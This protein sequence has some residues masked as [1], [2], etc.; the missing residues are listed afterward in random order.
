MPQE[1]PIILKG[2]KCVIDYIKSFYRLHFFYNQT[3]YKQ[4]ALG[5]QFGKQNLGPIHIE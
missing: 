5:T 2:D 3:D 4:L 1:K